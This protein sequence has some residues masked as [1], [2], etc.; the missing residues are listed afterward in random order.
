[1]PTDELRVC[2][3]GTGRAG[4]I[5]ARNYATAVPEARLVAGCDPDGDALGRACSELQIERGFA[6]YREAVQESDIDAVIVAAPTIYHH[7]IVVAAAQAR[8]H[9]FCEKPMAMNVTECREMIEAAKAAGVKLQI[10]FM[11]RFDE[12]FRYARARI[13]AKRHECE[14]P[15]V[16]EGE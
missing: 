15:A 11:R 1:M 7:E 16:I 9:V 4:M 14:F 2:V 3:I 5:H 10:G 12:G 13:E 8:K 6:D